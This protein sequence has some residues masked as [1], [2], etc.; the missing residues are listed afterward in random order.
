MGTS[1]GTV[2]LRREVMTQRDAPGLCE[3]FWRSFFGSMDPYTSLY[4]MKALKKSQYE[5]WSEKVPKF[6]QER[7]RRVKPPEAIATDFWY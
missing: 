7:H 2:V 5:A 6:F 4:A 3:G 1:S